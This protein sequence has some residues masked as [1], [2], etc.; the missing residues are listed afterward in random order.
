MIVAS[1]GFMVFAEGR[2]VARRG[3]GGSVFKGV[4]N[5]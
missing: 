3:F 4:G 2:F 1:L 5:R